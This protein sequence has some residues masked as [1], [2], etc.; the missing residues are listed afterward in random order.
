MK[1]TRTFTILFILALLLSNTPTTRHHLTRAAEPQ[2]N[3]NLSAATVKALHAPNRAD[4]VER[5]SASAFNLSSTSRLGQSSTGDWDIECVDCTDKFWW[6]TNRSLRLDS[7]GHPHIVYHGRNLHYTWHDGTKW[8]YE[9]VDGSP[10]V[11]IYATSLALD[12]ADHPHISYSD[13]SSG[14]LKYAWYDGLVW[15]IK[16]VDSEGN[17]GFSTLALDGTGRPHISYHDRDTGDLKYV[18]Y[19]GAAWQIETVDSDIGRYAS[20]VLDATGRPHISYSS[21]DLKY[22]WHNGTAWHIETVDNNGSVD[23]H[24]SLA[25]DEAGRPHISYN[26]GDLE[27][28]WHDRTTWH[29]ETV[30]GEGNYYEDTG[31]YSS[32]VFDGESQPYI[33]YGYFMH[34]G[35][36]FDSEQR[37]AWHD[38]TIWHIETI[39][40]V[41]PNEDWPSTSLVVD[42]AARPHISYGSSDLEYA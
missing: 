38:G 17:A 9:T 26:S 16:T 25:L 22:A 21:G 37:Y 18:W 36:Y 8:N 19:D 23:D 35:Y 13:A 32:L 29:I 24:T 3:T 34:D 4:V 2:V 27:Y 28:A 40:S 7:G 31:K 20:L 33:S 5:L 30:D 6:T 41:I 42:G 11:N 12:G 39:R 15:H 14:D 1:A 10:D